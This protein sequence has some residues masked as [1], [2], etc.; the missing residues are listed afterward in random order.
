[1]ELTVYGI[2][3]LRG[4]SCI[5]SYTTHKFSEKWSVYFKT[6]PQNFEALPENIHDIPKQTFADI[7]CSS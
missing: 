4:T 6:L 2:W 1:M 5:F 3:K 7:L